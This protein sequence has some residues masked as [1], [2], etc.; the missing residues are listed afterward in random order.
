M[1]FSTQ[2]RA[3]TIV[4]LE[5]RLGALCM[6][7]LETE[8]PVTAENFVGYVN[9]GSYPRSFFHL[10]NVDG[11]V[12]VQSGRFVFTGGDDLD[13]FIEI[14]RRPAII[15]ESS[16]SNT[17]GTVA[18]VPEDPADP[19]S[20][21]SQFLIN[22]SDNSSFLDSE[23]GGYT[24]FAR[25]I[26]DG[27]I[28]ADLV[29][30]LPVISLD[31]DGLSRVPVISQETPAINSL[32][33]DIFEA[34]IYD[35]D[36]NDFE[37]ENGGGD[38][39]GSD[40]GTDRGTDGGSDGGSDGGT[41][42][43]NDTGG[44]TPTPGE[45]ETLYEDAVCVDTNAGEFCMELLPDVAP[46]TA[47]NFLNYISDGRYDDTIIHRAV[48]NF[49]IQGGGYSSNPLGTP[50]PKDAAVVNEFSLSNVRGTVA[51]AR[52]GGQVNSATSE[53]FVNVVNNTS[54][55]TVDQG[56]TVFGRIISGMSVVDAIAAL[57]RADLRSNLGGAF[58][59]VPL[60][61]QDTDGVNTDDLVLVNRIY[62]TDVI[63]NDSDMGSGN[64]GGD[65][66]NGV[67]TTAT[68]TL[69]TDSF[70]LPVRIRDTLYRVLMIRDTAA[71]GAVFSVVTTRIFPLV[72]IGQETALMDLDAG[73]LHIPSMTVGNKIFTDLELSLTDFSTLTFK[74][75]SFN[76]P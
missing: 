4:C 67:Q 43:G 38:T 61:D 50:V 60:T 70:T 41:D 56:F 55:D 16:I 32:R 26:G 29:A 68:Y 54:L 14:P 76:K 30:A 11:A 75:E 65:P 72:D 64:G 28:L 17:R 42:G 8:A 22:L 37:A 20:A 33:V 9:R 21:T 2:A 6:E 34:Y 73:T 31:N 39:G 40:G 62:V 44:E 1:A 52:L 69:S 10:S 57:P 53:W 23:N 13:S 45:G 5:T 36:I 15:N 24:V 25:V 71:S 27:M 19:N 47:N 58:G 51:M 7:L 66:D 49:V 46:N 3:Q 12:Y 63:V 18:I 59:E 48:P 35:G 74:L